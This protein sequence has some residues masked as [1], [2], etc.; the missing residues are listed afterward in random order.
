[1]PP[2]GGF[3]QHPGGMPEGFTPPEGGMGGMPR[4]MESSSEVATDEFV[5]TRESCTFSNLTVK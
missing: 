5:L 4:G 2:E 3:G 1:M